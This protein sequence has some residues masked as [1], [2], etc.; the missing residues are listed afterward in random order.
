MKKQESCVDV[1]ERCGEVHIVFSNLPKHIENML[2]ADE[3]FVK[4]MKDQHAEMGDFVL[5]VEHGGF[6]KLN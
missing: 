5:V 2:N 4:E 3:D 6:S 1:F